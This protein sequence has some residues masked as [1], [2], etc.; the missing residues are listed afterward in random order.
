MTLVLVLI[1]AGCAAGKG[2]AGS[3]TTQEETT[4]YKE[5]TTVLIGEDN[6]PRPPDSTLSYGGREV[7]GTLGSYCWS[8]GSMH[9]CADAAWPVIP[10][11]RKTLTVPSASEMVFRYG[12]QR[13]PKVFRYR[14]EYGGEAHRK[15]GEVEAYSLKKLQKTGT[16]RP[17]STLK[18]HDS[19]VERTIPAELPRGE[20]VLEVLVMEQE[21]DVSYYFR[22]M[23]E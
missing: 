14:G 3:T 13:P 5:E 1:L 15:M 2:G 7:K 6:L 12:G 11:K 8:S 10:S 23:V 4:A 16:F 20:Y 21:D 22:I 17:D 9:V 18:V 19:G